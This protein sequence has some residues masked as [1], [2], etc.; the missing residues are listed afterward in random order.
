MKKVISVLI[1]AL[2]ALTACS[3]K[4]DVD[5]KEPSKTEAVSTQDLKKAI[6]ELLEVEV[7]SY[8]F[9]LSNENTYI[10]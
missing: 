6:D 3:P 8:I 2:F 5:K 1:V 7:I 4:Q 10:S 9:R